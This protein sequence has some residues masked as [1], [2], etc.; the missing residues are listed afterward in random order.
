M[1][2]HVV[3]EITAQRGTRIENET[4]R[5][6]HFDRTGPTENSGPPREVGDVFET[7]PVG[8]NRSIQF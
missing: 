5:Y 7:L 3:S 6:V 4:E 2:A 8:Q 1:L